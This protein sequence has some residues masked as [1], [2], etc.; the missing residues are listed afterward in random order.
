MQKFFADYMGSLETLHEELKR[1]I[2]GL[3]QAAL[4]WSPGAE[5]NSLCVMVVHVAGSERYWVGDIV[6]REDSGRDRE[7]EFRTQ[8]IDIAELKDHLEGSLTYVRRVLEGLSLE[9]LGAT[10]VPA[11][12]GR[13]FTTAWVLFHVLEHVANHLGHAQVTRQVWEQHSKE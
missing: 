12:D 8:G 3:P 11:R 13:E 2:E 4:D 1:T 10:C 6:A 9:D 7:A 5:M